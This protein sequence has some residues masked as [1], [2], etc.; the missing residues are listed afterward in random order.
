MY[1]FTKLHKS[2]IVP[3][4]RHLLIYQKGIKPGRYRFKKQQ[5]STA[6]SLCFKFTPRSRRNEKNISQT[7]LLLFLVIWSTLFY[8]Y[9][10]LVTDRKCQHVC[11]LFAI[12]LSWVKKTWSPQNIIHYLECYYFLTLFELQDVL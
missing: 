3:L 12:N 4:G 11:L 9:E 7:I 10:V 8:K 1:I 2:L 6:K 5:G